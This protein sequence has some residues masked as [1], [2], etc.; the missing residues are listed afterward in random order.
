MH[1]AGRTVHIVCLSI[2]MNLLRSGVMAVGLVVVVPSTA[3]AD[4]D[5]VRVAIASTA[6]PFAIEAAACALPELHVANHVLDVR[7]EGHRCADAAPGDD[8][9]ELRIHREDAAT[10]VLEA[11]PPEDG[12]DATSA[13]RVRAALQVAAARLKDR[14]A[15]A[16]APLTAPSRPRYELKPLSPT[17]RDLGGGL[18]VVGALAFATGLF[19]MGSN[20][21]FPGHDATLN[22]ATFATLA[23]GGGFVLIGGVMWLVGRV[24]VVRMT[25]SASPVGGSLRVTF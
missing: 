10:V 25:A 17:L 20:G 5:V 15:I 8:P 22:A 6:P 7:I 3:R 21:T 14:L 4:V 24:G 19:L 13:T 9:I 2:C 12:N 1:T 11:S 23:G 16:A 18:F